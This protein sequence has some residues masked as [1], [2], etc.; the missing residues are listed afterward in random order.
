M[1]NKKYFEVSIIRELTADVIMEV[2]EYVKKKELNELISSFIRRTD[3][4]HLDWEKNEYGYYGKKVSWYSPEK[5]DFDDEVKKSFSK[6][7]G[8]LFSV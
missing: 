8:N 3:L 5:I 7:K 4:D 1:K 6:E 2:D